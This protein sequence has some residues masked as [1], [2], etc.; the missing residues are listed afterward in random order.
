MLKNIDIQKI[1]SI[2]K[3]AGDEIMK[4]IYNL[5]EYNK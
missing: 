2:T 1:N 5:S 3:K 4:G